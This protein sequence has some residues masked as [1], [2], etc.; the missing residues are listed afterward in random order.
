MSN[1]IRNCNVCGEKASRVCDCC[2]KNFCGKKHLKSHKKSCFPRTEGLSTQEVEH[3]EKLATDLEEASLETFCET[4]KELL[5]SSHSNEEGGRAMQDSEFYGL[6]SVFIRAKGAPAFVRA[7][8][9]HHAQLCG[10]N[11]MNAISVLHIMSTSMR[12]YCQASLRPTC[13]VSLYNVSERASSMTL[14]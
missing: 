5:R 12:M 10:I 3:I 4:L 11:H 8:G 2:K 9:R 1:S 7:L 13:A 14:T 6:H